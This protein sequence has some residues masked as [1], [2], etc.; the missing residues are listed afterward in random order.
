MV[1]DLSNIP[2]SRVAPVACR[3]AIADYGSFNSDGLQTLPIT[4]PTL[5]RNLGPITLKECE[6]TRGHRHLDADPLGLV[7]RSGLMP[8]HATITDIMFSLA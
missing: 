2:Q 6:P 7:D 1:A 5:S 8:Y 4:K 3:A